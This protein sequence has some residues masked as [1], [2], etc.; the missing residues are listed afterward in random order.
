[1]SIVE[2][3]IK[4]LKFRRVWH[5]IESRK[6]SFFFPEYIS[7]KMKFEKTLFKCFLRSGQ[8][9]FFFEYELCQTYVR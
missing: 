7:R 2:E 5:K 8:K 3:G 1:M 9:L 4:F 6:T